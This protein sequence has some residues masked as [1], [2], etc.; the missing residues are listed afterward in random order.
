MHSGWVRAAALGILGAWFSCVPLGLCPRVLADPAGHGCCHRQPASQM[1]AAPEE[2]WVKSPAR[3]PSAPPPPALV[4]SARV[5]AHA[6]AFEQTGTSPR[7]RPTAFSP[8][9]IVLRI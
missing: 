4:V 2:C 6:S 5:A 1:T 9:A 7:S 8:L 3:T